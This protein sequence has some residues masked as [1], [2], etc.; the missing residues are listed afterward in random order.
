MPWGLNQFNGIRKRK[1]LILYEYYLA[2][3]RLAP[4]L[5]TV[6]LAGGLAFSQQH[7]LTIRRRNE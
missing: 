1:K 2:P 7:T 4:L 6:P 5:V 3:P